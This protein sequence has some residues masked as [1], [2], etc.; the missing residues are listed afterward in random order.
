MWLSSVLLGGGGGYT[1]IFTPSYWRLL[2]KLLYLLLMFFSSTNIFNFSWFLPQR[3]R[4]LLV[5]RYGPSHPRHTL[6]PQVYRE[7]V[8]D[9]WPANILH[10]HLRGQD[11]I[12]IYWTFICLVCKQDNIWVG[13]FLSKMDRF[14]G[15]KK[16]LQ[17]LRRKSLR[18][19][20][21]W[22]PDS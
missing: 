8:E 2:W 19:Q 13:T 16:V 15:R 6:N 21:S 5:A 4:L 17:A 22:T 12:K 3:V 14:E 1:I 20:E 18:L 10:S 11:F 9:V 7:V